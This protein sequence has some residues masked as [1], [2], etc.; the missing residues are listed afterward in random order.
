MKNLILVFANAICLFVLACL[1]TVLITT[2]G[3]CTKQASDGS[4]L[5]PE[6]MTGTQFTAKY[7]ITLPFLDYNDGST[8][9]R[10]KKKASD[11]SLSVFT[12]LTLTESLGVLTTSLSPDAEWGGVQKFFTIDTTNNG[13]SVC[14]WNWSYVMAPTSQ[15]CTSN[16]SGSY[17]S[18]T[19]DKLTYD[20]HLSPFL[21]Q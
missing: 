3:G 2:A 7:G 21:E 20:I 6:K 8:T 5:A 13:V 12:D 1:A 16:G 4:Q 15:T 19:S 14:N 9:A 11:V 17:R 18:W 10:G